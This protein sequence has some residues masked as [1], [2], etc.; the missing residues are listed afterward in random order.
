M[1]L[2]L[3]YNIYMSL[4]LEYSKANFNSPQYNKVDF[5]NIKIMTP[6]EGF[7]FKYYG[8]C[9]DK[10]V[11]WGSEKPVLETCLP[12]YLQMEGKSCTNIWNNS[13]KRKTMVID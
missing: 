4:L 12:Q 13:T 6:T 9:L 8:H 11:L 10:N 5:S 3:I 1:I 7:N 2:Y